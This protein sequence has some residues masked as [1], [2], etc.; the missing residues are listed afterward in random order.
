MLRP[1]VA[2]WRRCFCL[3][4]VA[5][6]RGQA[7]CDLPRFR[8]TPRRRLGSPLCGAAV[9]AGQ[10]NR[11]PPLGPRHRAARTNDKPIVLCAVDW[12]G[13]G[14]GGYDAWREALAEAAGTSVDRVAVHTLHQ[15]DA[16]SCDFDAEALLASRGTVRR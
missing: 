1:L 3:V 9:R 5:G 4:A 13:I 14:G 8:S 7:A 10:G 11:R 12:V 6:G 2:L 16:P 15:H